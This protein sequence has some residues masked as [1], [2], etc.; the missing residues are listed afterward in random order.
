MNMKNVSTL[1]DVVGEEI[2]VLVKECEILRRDLAVCETKL[3]AAESRISSVM[4][5]DKQI[6]FYNQLFVLAVSKYTT[7]AN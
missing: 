7:V 1:T 2:E 4:Y 6:Q 5:D 3:N